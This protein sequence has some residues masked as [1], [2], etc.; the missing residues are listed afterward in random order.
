MALIPFTMSRYSISCLSGSKLN[1]YLPLNKSVAI[2]IYLGYTVMLI[3]FLATIIFIAFFGIL[4]SEGDKVYCDALT[5]EIM[6]T[7]YCIS[8]VSLLMARS[9]Q[10]NVEFELCL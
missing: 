6:I 3:V 1:R 5:S 10:I 4:C 9:V 8:G 7:G 2:H